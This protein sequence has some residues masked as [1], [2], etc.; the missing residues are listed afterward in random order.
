MVQSLEIAENLIFADA[1]KNDSPYLSSKLMKISFGAAG[2][3]TRV[4]DHETL[5]YITFAMSGK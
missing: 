4:A 2:R 1:G 5:L 3:P